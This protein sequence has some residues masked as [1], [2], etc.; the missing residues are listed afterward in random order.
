LRRGRGPAGR[1]PVLRLGRD[2][3]S[4]AVSLDTISDGE[5]DLL[6]PR[7]PHVDEDATQRQQQPGSVQVMEGLASSDLWMFFGVP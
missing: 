7:L 6:N 4:F 5:R 1:N 3:E 2:V